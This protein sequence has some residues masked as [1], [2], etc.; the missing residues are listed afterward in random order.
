MQMGIWNRLAAAP[1]F[2]R[3]ASLTG[4]VATFGLLAVAPAAEAL[5]TANGGEPAF[6]K[7]TSNTWWYTWSSS[8]ASAYACFTLYAN[9][10]SQGSK[11]CTSTFTGTS[12]TFSKQLTGLTSGVQYSLCAQEWDYISGVGYEPWGTAA[13][14]AT[15]MDNSIPSASTGVDGTANYTND[16]N[17]TLTINYSDSISPPWPGGSTFDC[18]RKGASTG[19]CMNAPTATPNTFQFDSG[20]SSPTYRNTTSYNTSNWQ[21]TYNIS[22]LRNF[23]DGTWYY[24]VLEAD[25]AVPDSSTWTTTATSNQA[26]LSP[27]APNS[28][29]YI[30]LD[31][32]PPTVSPG[33]NATTV[34]VG[35]LVSF[36]VSSSDATSGTTGSYD[37]DFGDNTTHGSGASPTHTYTQPG[38]YAVTVTTHDG[39]GNTGTG[40]LTIQ[41]NSPSGSGTG[42]TGGS[43]GTGG[44]GGGNGGSSGGSGGGSGSSAGPTGTGGFSSNTHNCV[45]PALKGKSKSA[46]SSALQ[47]AGCRLGKVTAP[48]HPPRHRAGKHHKW[49]LVVT[50][51]SP[52]AHRSLG[53]GARVNVTLGYVLERA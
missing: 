52:G 44:T 7:G 42:G 22:S 39:A 38:T 4:V 18:W 45:V 16:P 50:G 48:K 51:Q 19:Q 27:D 43:G 9:G 32:V 34:N 12:Q 17:M 10:A 5:S 35:Q 2:A 36:N 47:R 15:T 21:C 53:L 37:W 23:S 24:C 28:C 25:S 30:T 41:V 6:T 46:A 11:G 13:C 14:G 49:A 8:G 33:A 31:R 1:R 3:W 20:C 40:H 29:G 26:N